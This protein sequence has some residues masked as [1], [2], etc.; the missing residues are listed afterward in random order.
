M[1]VAARVGEKQNTAK[2][3]TVSDGSGHLLWPGAD[4]PGRMRDRAAL[5]T[6][7]IAEQLWTPP[8]VAAMVDEGHRGPADG[9]PDQVQA[10][11]RKPTDEAP[12]GEKYT[13][14]EARR[15]QSSRICGEH[16]TGEVQNPASEPD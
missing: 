3:T 14:R 6:E 5:R 12:P 16:T 9:F 8:Q 10:P 1:T 15:R 7:G 2:T 11:P 4:R 13:W